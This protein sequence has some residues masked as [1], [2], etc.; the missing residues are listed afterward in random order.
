VWRREE[1]GDGRDSFDHFQTSSSNLFSNWNRVLVAA[2]ASG[3]KGCT[4]NWS[5]CQPAVHT[6]PWCC[7]MR[8][9]GRRCSFF[10]WG[11]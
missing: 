1:K 8:C 10:L 7:P 6:A 5:P 2:P 4:W 3:P 9:S 11:G